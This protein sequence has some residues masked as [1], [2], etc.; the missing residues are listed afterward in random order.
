VLGSVSPGDKMQAIITQ[1]SGT[2]WTLSI[3][4][5][6]SGTSSSGPLTYAGLGLS[7]EWIEELPAT[8][9]PPQPYLAN[10]GSAQFTHLALGAGDPSTTVISPVDMVDGIGNVIASTGAISSQS[11]PV[12]YVPEQATTVVSANPTSSTSGSSVTYSATVS[13]VGPAPTGAVAITDGIDLSL[14]R[15]RCGGHA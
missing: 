5:V 4:D 14:F 10:F 11:F 1:N 3:A 9:S 6:T 12:T 15:S 7:A 8:A 2:N 13:S